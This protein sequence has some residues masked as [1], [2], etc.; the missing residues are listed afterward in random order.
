MRVFI[1]KIIP[2]MGLNLLKQAG[3][4]ITMWQEDRV[5]TREEA[6]ENCLAHDAFLNVGQKGVDADFLE[7]CKHL[8]VI[9]MH[10][11]GF[12]NVDVAAA[13]RLNIPIGN[14]PGVLNK[15]TAEIAL[16]LMLTVSRKALYLHKRIAEGGWGISQPT[17]DLGVD[18]NGKTL[19]IVGLGRIGAELG[20]MCQ[21]ALG[22]K[23]VYH[24]RTSNPIAEKALAAQKVP[25]D[26]LLA[27]S[28]VVSVHTALTTETKGMFG[29]QEFNKMK[30]SA[31]FINTAR[32]GIVRENE[33]I[34]ALEEG[35]IW[36]AGLDVT[37]P[38][39]ID[40]NSPLLSLENSVVFPHIG[41]S[42]KETRDAMSRLAAE[43][44]IAGLRGEKLP[45]PVNPEVYES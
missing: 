33:L 8:K 22:M 31:I 12:D 26:D 2:E 40:K 14:T 18:L 34:R 1:N 38:E 29:W 3:V 15:A 35:I 42:T 17:Q 21:Q 30:S 44:I 9:A 41:S 19:G 32:G 43:N 23:V 27:L 5:L 37:D 16:L 11:V 10:S 24:N 36:G 45:Y 13:T 25:F 20:R 39:P 28:D 4:E 7:Q 6:I